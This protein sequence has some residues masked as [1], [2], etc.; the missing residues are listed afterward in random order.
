[1]TALVAEIDACAGGRTEAALG[2]IRETMPL[3][4]AGFFAMDLLFE[5][6]DTAAGRDLA[7]DVARQES[8]GPLA[9]LWLKRLSELSESVHDRLRALDAAVVRA[10][11]LSSVRWGRFEARLDQK[12]LEGALGDAEHLEAAAR[13]ARARHDVCARVG[14]ALLDAGFGPESGKW[15]ERALRYAPEDERATVGLARAFVACGR[16]QRAV[17]LLERAVSLA[18]RKG[19]TDGEVL[20]EL[21]KLLAEVLHDLPQAI[22]RLSEVPLS[23]D[24]AIEAR[25]READYRARLGDIAGA[26][27]AY[28][29][30]RDSLELAA[31]PPLLEARWLVKAARF[32]REIRKDLVAAERHLAVALRLLPK[33][34]AIGAAYRGVAGE[35]AESLQREPS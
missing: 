2:L 11:Q 12:S 16:H 28:A 34:S 35:L 4:R 27:L 9:A 15:F 20:V 32:E 21:A 1:L 8:F 22:F 7:Y 24:R 29:R 23:S 5:S 13:G 19:T 18:G 6:G 3:A 30:F 10:P 26:S 25:F 17:S 14:K 33:D 31:E